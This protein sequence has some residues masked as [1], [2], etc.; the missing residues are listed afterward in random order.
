M[1]DDLFRA[2]ALKA[3]TGERWGRPVG[4][5][6]LA[7]SRIT[8]LL[9]C[10]VAAVVVFIFT[11]SFSRKETVRGRLR[12][13]AAEA[14]IFAPDAGT[15]VRLHVDLGD[16]VSAGDVLAEI[17]TA[18]QIDQDTN[19][20]GES[21][22]S[23]EREREILETRRASALRDT[24]LQKS[25]MRIDQARMQAE[26]AKYSET[27]EL[28]GQRMR[29]AEESLA[30]SRRLQAEGAASRAEERTRE[31]Q[32][33][34]LK[35]QH[36]D[37]NGR[38]ADTSA[39]VK[40]LAL[41]LRRIDEELGRLLADINQRLAQIDSQVA[42]TRAEAGFVIKAPVAGRVAA[43][44]A[45]EGERV[46]P[47]QPVL[48]IIPAS[49]Q[50]IAE[51]YVPSR[52]IA[53]IE[54]G[55]TVRLRYD[56]LPYQKF[57]TAGG[58]VQSVSET[59]FTPQEIRTQVRVEEPVYRVSIKL[60]RQDM[61]AFGKEVP[62]QPGMELSADIVLEKRKVVDWLMEPLRASMSRMDGVS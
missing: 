62:L 48:A 16:L 44:Q 17:A 30:A 58:T 26:V 21:L 5:L 51:T 29:L 7:W 3:Q 50:L 54:P 18:R 14:R 10:F 19:L 41:D 40:T 32:M 46:D 53:F 34:M 61:P 9:F 42:R 11:A 6:P 13:T 20:S 31:D 60:D 33:L 24:E 37:A 15:I 49:G 57:G 43:L 38:F 12:P 52:A 23:L 45:I 8:L 55:Q 28:T 36:L 25:R 59:T 39:Q 35:Q 1:A 2:E 56:A 22:L 4:L 47:S 27:A